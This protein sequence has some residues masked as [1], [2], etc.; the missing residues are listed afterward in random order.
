MTNSA[1]RYRYTALLG[2]ALTSM[3]LAA[4]GEEAAK[5]EGPAEAAVPAA[6]PV[7]EVANALPV[8]TG[9]AAASITAGQL[10]SFQASAADADGDTLT[11]SAQ[12]LP[13]W[14]TLDAVAGRVSGMPDDA[15]AGD[16]ADITVSATDG[17]A[18]ASLQPFRIHVAA[19]PAAAPSTPGIAAPVISGSPA[20]TVTAG[21]AY[22][23]IPV[24]T[25]A[26]SLTLSFSIT[27]KPVWASFSSSTGRL[28]G[29]PSSAQVA[30][31]ANIVIRVSDGAKSAALPAFTITVN[32]APNRAPMIAGTPATTVS[33]GSAYSFTPVA[34]DA[35]N[36]TLGFSITN[37]PTWATF[38]TS[39]GKLSG[40]PVGAN[41]GTYAGIVI[42]VSDGKVN[43]ALASFSIAVQAAANGAPTIFGTP[44]AAV[45]AGAAYSFQPT[46]ADPNSDTLAYSISGKPS[47]ASF[48]TTTGALTG[49]PSAA[50]AG[51]YGNIVISVSD[52]KL[53]SALAA[54][55]ITVTQVAT[56][57]ATLSW[58][59]PTQNTDGSALSNL[60]GYRIYYGNDPNSLTSSIQITNPGLTTY[61]IGNLGAGTHYFAIASYTADGVESA[62]S[63]VGSKTI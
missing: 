24:A 62:M 59:P 32:A 39:T 56:G 52:G 51:S 21:A 48:S 57:S 55:S 7:S 3:L 34:A 5:G 37:K 31:Y 60:A 17:K 38:S 53:T 19:R 49:S 9:T 2:I 10:Y 41:V 35:D 22:S 11:F 61:V 46:G 23:F 4:C 26:D 50:Q 14:A 27:N 45:N 43:A 25:D 42:S 16:T 13:D 15:D 20:V 12:G 63:G 6:S 33:A 44:A 47:W 40:T 54:F 18:T 29:T 30:S 1:R 58:T 28:S 8:I 36:N